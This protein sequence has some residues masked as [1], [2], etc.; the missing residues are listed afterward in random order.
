M[1]KNI[2]YQGV[3][4]YLTPESEHTRIKRS[5]ITEDKNM[6]VKFFEWFKQTFKEDVCIK[7]AEILTI[8]TKT[9]QVKI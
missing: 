4:E 9:K 6:V 1:S 8:T 2:K 5:E 7:K 3:I